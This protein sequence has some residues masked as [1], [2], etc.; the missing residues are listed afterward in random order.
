MIALV[1]VLLGFIIG[2][3]VEQVLRKALVALNT[4][5]RLFKI[6]KARRNY[7]RAIR[8]TVVRLIYLATVVIALYRLSLAEGVFTFIIFLAVFTAIISLVLASMDAVPNLVGRLAL[9]RR[10][11]AVGDEIVLVDSTGAIHG[12]IVDMTLT[13][14]RIKR[15]NGDLFIIP[16]VLFIKERVIKKHT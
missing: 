3:I 16:N 11:I 7:A 15:K 9:N 6:F 5:E 8:R 2:R 13:D 10:H 14:V 12:V 1:I 4:D